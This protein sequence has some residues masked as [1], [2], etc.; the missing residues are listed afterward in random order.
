MRLLQPYPNHRSTHRIEEDRRLECSRSLRF[1]RY[2]YPHHSAPSGYDRICD[3]ISSPEVVLPV[4]LHLLGETM[5]RPLGILIS[6]FGGI[7]E[8]S[9]YDF[10][11]ELAVAVDMMRHRNCT[12]H[13]I[14][15]EKSC[16][17][18]AG[19]AGWRGHRLIGTV[20]HPAEQQAILFNDTTHF[21]A[22]DL[23]LCMDT[24]SVAFWEQVTGKKN[25]LQ[26]PH[27]VDTSYFRPIDDR[28]PDPER[29]LVFAGS[30]L[31]DFDVLRHVVRATSDN[32]AGMR[33]HWDL[34]GKHE[35]LK[36][37]ASSHHSVSHHRRADDETYRKLL[38]E[39]DL[40]VMPLQASTT[41][42]AALE[43][44]ACGTPV[45]TTIGGIQSYLDESCAAF[46]RAG[47][48]VAMSETVIAL[49][50]DPD[51]LS[52]MRVAAREQ[53]A[54][55]DWEVVAARHVDFYRYMWE[56]EPFAVA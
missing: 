20:H 24:R 50:E 42:T 45:V 41:C 47:D 26:V 53:A 28:R 11:M 25:V 34:I 5:L 44:I 43:A 51:R 39:A 21:R 1:V 22:F 18:S 19:L 52:S 13:F 4:W 32:D 17:L 40:L 35:V 9:R 3:F 56:R 38:A 48:A 54:R 30:H 14:Y 2:R 36:E 6:R 12:Y 46:C 15:A 16:L 55:F 7:H 23:L 8:Y 27:G 10:T 49:L 37:L 31:R 33:I 29:R